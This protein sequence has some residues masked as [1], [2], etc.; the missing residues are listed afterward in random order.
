MGEKC[1]VAFLKLY[2]SGANLL[3]LDEPANYFDVETKEK[4]EQ[5]LQGFTG[6]FVVVSHDRYLIGKLATRLLF[7]GQDSV[8]FLYEGSWQEY[9]EEQNR[10]LQEPD[11]PEAADEVR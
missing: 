8:L 2:F 4:V 1:R 11:N 5:A 3:V 6:A 10:K 9:E 7:L